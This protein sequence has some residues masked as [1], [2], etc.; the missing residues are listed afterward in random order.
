MATGEDVEVVDTYD[1]T[2]YPEYDESG[3]EAGESGEEAD[4]KPVKLPRNIKRVTRREAE[5]EYRKEHLFPEVAF[6]PPSDADIRVMCLEHQSENPEYAV[7][8]QNSPMSRF[9]SAV[10]DYTRSVQVC[11]TRR[12]I[13]TLKDE[14]E[15]DSYYYLLGYS[16]AGP[17]LLQQ[18]RSAAFAF[19]E[20]MERYDGGDF[21]GDVLLNN[22]RYASDFAMIVGLQIVTLRSTSQSGAWIDKKVVKRNQDTIVE[23]RR[24]LMHLLDSERF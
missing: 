9:T 24:H 3:T 8:K 17:T 7:F 21:F 23:A 22:D 13:F 11:L 1:D 2:G 10:N 15:E 5:G 18:I 14:P 12:L 16:V 6:M 20:Y 19:D 4:P